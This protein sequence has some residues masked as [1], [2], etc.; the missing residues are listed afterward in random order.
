MNDSRVVVIGSGA[1]GAAFAWSMASA[2]VKVQLLEAGP[3]Y[4]PA[5]DYKLAQP[6][7]ENSRFPAKVPW[8]DRQTHAPMQALDKKW[9]S[10]QSWNHLKAD[11]PK[12]KQRGFGGYHHVVGVGGSTLHYTGESH[13]MNPA[14]MAMHSRFGVAADWP[15]TYRELE[16]Y[17]C[18]A[19]RTIG[20]AGPESP[21]VRLR[22]EPY[23]VPAHQRSYA[24]Q[25][26]GRGFDALGLSWTPNPVAS[27]S[28][29]YDGRPPCN[30]CGQCTRGCPR[31][32]KGTADITFVA[33]ALKTG[34][35]SLKTVSQVLRLETGKSGRVEAAIY[36]DEKG[37]EHRVTGDLFVVACGSVETP[38]LLLNSASAESP[39]GLGN[40]SGQIGRNF[41][42]TLM[43]ASIGLHPEPLG[44]YRG[45]PTDSICWDFNAPDAIDGVIGGCRLSQMTIEMGMDG[46]LNYARRVVGGWGKQHKKNMREQFG[47]ALALGGICESLPNPGT[48]IDLDP[49][50]KD[51]FGLPKA[52]IHSHLDDMAFRR[53]GFIA[54]KVREILAAAGVGK[55]IEEISSVDYFNSTHVFGTCRMGQDAAESVVDP[56]C[57]NHRWNNLMVVDASVFPSSG[58]GESP[59]LTIY[60]NALRVAEAARNKGV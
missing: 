2:G 29:P 36:A 21:G 41:M 17:Y 50:A 3:S 26:L 10:I 55:T 37:V 40:E 20:V 15:L 58:G 16:P 45:L 14:S 35:C 59:S 31:Y 22:S 56:D 6:D 57:R 39:G 5:T 1:G 25:V 8:R 52:R 11:E 48:F 7:W 4:N 53:I 32:D 18:I 9:D 28:R 24:S 47:R 49:E 13:R 19:E 42:E 33:K 43:F 38:R 54:S 44:S 30:Y 27:L 12:K 51:K 60:A 46:P 23:P 34:N